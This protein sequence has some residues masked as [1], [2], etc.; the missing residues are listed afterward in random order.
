MQHPE[1]TPVSATLHAAGFASCFSV[2]AGLIGFLGTAIH[3]TAQVAGAGL[4]YAEQF[5]APEALDAATVTK[6]QRNVFMVAVIPAMAFALQ[7]RSPD[8]P[9][10]AQIKAAIPFFVVG[11]V[12][13]SL[14]RTLGDAGAAPFWGLI[15]TE[16][17]S[18]LIAGTTGLSKALLTV[19]MASVGLG[20]SFARLRGL[21]L[22]PLA[23]GL[24]AATLVGGMSYALVSLIGPFA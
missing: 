11:F 21:G 2:I 18:A 6:L 4:V 19:A 1:G 10:A 22:R 9:L 14:L 12:A 15:S 3:D 8:T 20:T 5:G 7:K 24:A 23:V 13:M 16:A 17:W